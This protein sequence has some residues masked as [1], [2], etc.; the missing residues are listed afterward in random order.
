MPLSFGC[1]FGN[2]MY[3][4]QVTCKL[5]NLTLLYVYIYVPIDVEHLRFERS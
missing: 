3:N 2:I 5:F 1:N 4:D